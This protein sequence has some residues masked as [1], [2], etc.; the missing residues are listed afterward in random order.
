M[1]GDIGS[2]VAEN[3]TAARSPLVRLQWMPGW[4]YWFGP[5]MP[6]WLAGSGFV[7]GLSAVGTAAE[8]AVGAA[9]PLSHL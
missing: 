1:V 8:E 2:A 7:A 6:G 3:T 9:P 4:G 5:G